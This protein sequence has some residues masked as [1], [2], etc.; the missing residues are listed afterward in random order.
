MTFGLYVIC[1]LLAHMG[2][3]LVTWGPLP[4]TVAGYL[5]LAVSGTGFAWLVASHVAWRMHGIPALRREF[6][7]IITERAPADVT[8]V[9]GVEHVTFSAQVKGIGPLRL[10]TLVRSGEDPARDLWAAGPGATGVLG[11]DAFTVATGEPGFRRHTVTARVMA[12]RDA[13]VP[14][15]FPA[16]GEASL[17]A[18]FGL[19]ITGRAED[20]AG[21]REAIRQFQAAEAL[22]R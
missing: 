9:N 13:L 4:A 11:G 1:G 3:D 10:Y 16:P 6:I 5:V 15:P 19:R 17:S 18:I 12:A 20:A 21:L 14:D 7:A 2:V 8:W 22:P